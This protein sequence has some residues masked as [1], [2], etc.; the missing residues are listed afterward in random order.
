MP[1]STHSQAPRGESFRSKQTGDTI[2]RAS[3]YRSRWSGEAL[4]FR[5][6]ITSATGLF[7]RKG[8]LSGP[9]RKVGRMGR[10]SERAGIRERLHGVRPVCWVCINLRI[11][12]GHKVIP[13][14]TTWQAPCNACGRAIITLHRT[15]ASMLRADPGLCR[16]PRTGPNPECPRLSACRNSGNQSRRSSHVQCACPNVDRRRAH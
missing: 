2:L 8:P 15:L 9:L 4:W 10:V 1:K 5:S 16:R 11:N 12:F 6:P 14:W 7:L 13:L 3:S